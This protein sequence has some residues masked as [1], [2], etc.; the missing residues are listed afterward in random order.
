MIHCKTLLYS[1]QSDT[2]LIV[3]FLQ[4]SRICSPRLTKGSEENSSRQFNSNVGSI[5]AAVSRKKSKNSEEFDANWASM[6]GR[7]VKFLC[8]PRTG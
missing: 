1:L 6:G 8:L 4:K 7:K 2:A 5:F 3:L